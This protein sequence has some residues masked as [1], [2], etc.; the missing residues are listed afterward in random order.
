M[1]FMIQIVGSNVG[2]YWSTQF[3]SPTRGNSETKVVVGAAEQFSFVGFAHT[4]SA[5]NL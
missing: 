5:T 1:K 4:N 2:D 3:G